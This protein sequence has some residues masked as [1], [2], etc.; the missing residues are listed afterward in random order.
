ML[1]AF[2][3]RRAVKMAGHGGATTAGGD[4]GV[5]YTLFDEWFKDV[6]EAMGK[7]ARFI[8]I[9]CVEGGLPTAG[10]LIG[11]DDLQTEPF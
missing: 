10:L 11:K 4:N 8:A 3:E 9:S 1:L 5:H 2:K 7:G 6:D